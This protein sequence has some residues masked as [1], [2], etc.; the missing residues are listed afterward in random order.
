MKSIVSDIFRTI[1][2][3]YRGGDVPPGFKA[4]IGFDIDG[5]RRTVS[6]DGDDCQVSDAIAEGC[7]SVI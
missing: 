7:D 5:I 3:R 2:T 1:P 6:M 4:R